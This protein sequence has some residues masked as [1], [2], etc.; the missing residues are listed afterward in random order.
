MQGEARSSHILHRVLPLPQG[1]AEDAYAALLAG[2]QKK[3]PTCDARRRPGFKD[4]TGGRKN[5]PAMVKMGMY[6]AINRVP[7][8]PPMNTIMAGSMAEV[9]A[10]TAASTSSS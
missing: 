5:Q 3:D 4:R 8:T 10:A 7:T 9:I 1:I 2:K 6:M